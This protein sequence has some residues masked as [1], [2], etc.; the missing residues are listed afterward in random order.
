MKAG[1]FLP[2]VNRFQQRT[3]QSGELFYFRTIGQTVLVWRPASAVRILDLCS[4]IAVP[5][6]RPQIVRHKP[7]L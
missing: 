6:H 7:L 1:I 4:P 5:Q 3:L 2:I